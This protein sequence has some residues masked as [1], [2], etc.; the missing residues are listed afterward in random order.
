MGT[1]ADW[2]ISASTR[3]RDSADPHAKCPRATTDRAATGA[4]IAFDANGMLAIA[5]VAQP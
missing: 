2:I 4:K 1:P 5:D 3:R